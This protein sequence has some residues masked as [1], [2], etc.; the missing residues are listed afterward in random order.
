VERE[1]NAKKPI[2]I[3]N[4]NEFQE[5]VKGFNSN[6]KKKIPMIMSAKN[7]NLYSFRISVKVVFLCV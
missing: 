7:T 4:D 2:E 5:P 1:G 3:G 6:L